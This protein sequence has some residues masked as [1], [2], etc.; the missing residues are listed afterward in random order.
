MIFAAV[1]HI[2]DIRVLRGLPD[3]LTRRAIHAAQQIRFQPAAIDGAPVNVRGT[4][5]F[6]FRL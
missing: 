1:G 2:T 5:E 3:G 4:V 6:T